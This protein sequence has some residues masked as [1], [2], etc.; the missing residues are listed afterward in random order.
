MK[1]APPFGLHG[2]GGGVCGGLR[3][4]GG[5]RGFGGCLAAVCLQAV[6]EARRMSALQLPQT[7][8]GA[9]TSL[10]LRPARHALLLQLRLLSGG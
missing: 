3:G 6:V 5:L 2:D 7:S 8:L 9:R 10:P 4:V 1:H